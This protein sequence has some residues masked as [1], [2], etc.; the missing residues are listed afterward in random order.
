MSPKAH[1]GGLAG[2]PRLVVGDLH[3]LKTGEVQP[4]K[5]AA[6]EAHWHEGAPGEGVPLV[7]FAVPNAEEERN[8]FELA[9]PRL[10]SVILT[11]SWDGEV[12][13]LT[14]VPAS[15]RPPIAPVFWGFRI[16]VGLG[17]AMLVLALACTLLPFAL[18][19]VALRHMSAFSAQLAVNLEPVYAIVLAILL[20]G[21]QR[22]LTPAF[23]AG[24]A[25][26]MAAVLV[27]PLLSRRRGSAAPELHAENLV[28]G[29]AR[30]LLDTRRD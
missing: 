13:P 9:I 19:L 10:G 6:I 21:E 5:L 24:V 1:G 14:A 28:T 16:M 23:Y 3:G 26:I 25:I 15:E 29:E 4:V 18:S 27:H 11:H 2:H 22:E 17:V 8:D 30:D 7:V 20:L 12:E